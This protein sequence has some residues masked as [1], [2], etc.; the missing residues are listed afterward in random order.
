MP[1]TRDAARRIAWRLIAPEALND[2][3]A[4]EREA[5]LWR[6]LPGHVAVED[7]E[8]AVWRGA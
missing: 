5:E 4:F 3:V 6:G 7:V 2:V 8:E 1:A